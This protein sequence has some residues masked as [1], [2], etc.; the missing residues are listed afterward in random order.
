[1]DAF[2]LNEKEEEE[3]KDIGFA[4]LFDENGLPVVR[5]LEGVEAPNMEIMFGMLWSIV[6]QITAS[7]FVEKADE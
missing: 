1:M 7:N 2:A 4:V 5:Q 3:K 6:G